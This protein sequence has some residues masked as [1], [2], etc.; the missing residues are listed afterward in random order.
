MFDDQPGDSCGCRGL[1]MADEVR[2]IKG[3]GQVL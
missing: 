2:D 3:W 1:S